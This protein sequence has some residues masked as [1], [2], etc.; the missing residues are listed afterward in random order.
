MTDGDAAALLLDEAWQEGPLGLRTV[1]A[2]TL[3]PALRYTASPSAVDAFWQAYG[4]ELGAFTLY[5]SGDFHHLTRLLLRRHA[6]DQL[7]VVV[8]DNHPD[9]DLRPPRW[10]CGGW[11]ARAERLPRVEQIVVWG[12]GNFELKLPSRAFAD[13]RALREGRLRVH[14][15]AERQPESVGRRF[16]CEGLD[17]W[18]PAFEEFAAGLAGARVY[19]SVDLD[20]L[21]AEDAVTNWENGLF[22]PADVAWAIRTLR[23]Q[24]RLVGGDV[25]GAYSPQRYA[26]ARQRFAARWDHP[27]VEPPPSLEQARRVNERAVTPIWAALTGA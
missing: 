1:D 25:C 4:G 6:R 13:H 15:W 20:C 27:H 17:T 26:R 3:G 2:R 14:A 16:P 10:G 24:A 8:F 5:G 11:T 9:W 23:A 18:R 19:V 7:V 21:R 22:R 12:C